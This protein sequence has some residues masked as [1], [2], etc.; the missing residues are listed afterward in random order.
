MILITSILFSSSSKLPQIV[1]NP[2]LHL[3]I[4]LN[5]LLSLKL[6][7]HAPSPKLPQHGLRLLRILPHPPGNNLPCIIV[8][9]LQ[10]RHISAAFALAVPLRQLR[11]HRV[12]VSLDVADVVVATADRA[13]ASAHEFV[14]EDVLAEEEVQDE[15]DF[16]VAVENLE[17]GFSSWKTI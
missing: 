6:H 9:H 17:L 8:P 10:F 15:V 11:L 13:G 1:H 4:I 3:R 2:P 16:E 12:V 7:E 14:D 5:P